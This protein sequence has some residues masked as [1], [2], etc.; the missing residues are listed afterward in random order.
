MKCEK[1]NT[2]MNFSRKGSCCEWSCPNCE[3]AIVTTY[4]SPM[5]L[6]SKKYLLQIDICSNPTNQMLRCI[7][8]LFLCNFIEAKKILQEG[9]LTI[10]DLATT[11]NKYKIKLDDASVKYTIEPYFPYD[12]NGEI[13]SSNNE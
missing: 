12:S 8:K 10:S 2:L 11:I 13:F 9:T 1:C 4:H 7:S 6:D 5:E 3:W